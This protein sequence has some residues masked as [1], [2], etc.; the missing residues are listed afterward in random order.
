MPVRP[1]HWNE[2]IIKEE[3]QRQCV[4]S[5]KKACDAFMTGRKYYN[6]NTTVY[7][8]SHDG[9]WYLQLHGNDIAK[10]K[11]KKIWVRACGWGTVTTKSRLN[12]IPGVQVYSEKYVLHLNGSPWENHQ[13][14]TLVK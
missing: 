4:K 12:G 11:G 3:R 14:W 13:D 8:S 5:P 9:A 1:L 6:D 2:G 10:R 7:E